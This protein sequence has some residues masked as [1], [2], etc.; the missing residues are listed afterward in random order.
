MI[1]PNS[2]SSAVSP[3]AAP[4][5]TTTEAASTTYVAPTIESAFTLDDMAREVLYAGVPVSG[6]GGGPGGG[7]A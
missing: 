2:P 6:G 5:V 4:H 3:E 1:Q 7:P